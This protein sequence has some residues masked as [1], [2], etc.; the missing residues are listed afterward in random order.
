M[1]KVV[2]L[3]SSGGWDSLVLVGKSSRRDKLIQ[4]R[5]DGTR[6]PW[7]ATD[8]GETLKKSFTAYRRESWLVDGQAT[9]RYRKCAK[10]IHRRPLSRMVPKLSG[11][12][13]KSFINWHGLTSRW[14][15]LLRAPLC[16]AAPNG[17]SLRRHLCNL[18]YIHHSIP[19]L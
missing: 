6:Q 8:L 17:S 4:I 3:V 16:M 2:I 15:G 12:S 11:K 19:I 9:H 7:S 18:L 13:W 5:V 10:L 1:N 14:I